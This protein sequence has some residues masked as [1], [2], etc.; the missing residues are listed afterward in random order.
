M[1]AYRKKTR[2]DWTSV[3]IGKNFPLFLQDKC[4]LHV[5]STSSDHRGYARAKRSLKKSMTDWELAHKFYK[6][7]K[8]EFVF[9]TIMGTESK[10]KLGWEN[11]FWKA[12][13]TKSKKFS[14][15]HCGSFRKKYMKKIRFRI[16]GDE[17]GGFSSKQ[18]QWDL[19]ERHAEW[20][21]ALS[22]RNE[23]TLFIKVWFLLSAE[24]PKNT[25]ITTKNASVCKQGSKQSRGGVQK[26]D[27]YRSRWIWGRN[28]VIL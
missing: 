2:T 7:E 9:T 16:Y 8:K 12:L 3:V 26:P 17:S 13:W 20:K 1:I 22:L 24:R 18:E 28:C 25:T 10:C 27:Y 19:N 6:R 11:T 14:K 5:T 15:M 21:L 4:I 23:K